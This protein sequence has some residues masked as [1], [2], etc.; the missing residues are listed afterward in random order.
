MAA[1]Q[2]VLRLGMERASEEGFG[3]ACLREP[4]GPGRAEK[5][6]KEAASRSP[7]APAFEGTPNLQ[8]FYLL[9]VL[10][11]FCRPVMQNMGFSA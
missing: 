4:W 10:P 6:I 8:P 5:V 3:G 1:L 7:A 2:D 9:T 11:A